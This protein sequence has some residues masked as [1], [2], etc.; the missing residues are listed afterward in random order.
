MLVELFTQLSR[1]KSLGAQHRSL[2]NCVT[3]A[4]LM[5]RTF[6]VQSI[7]VL[8]AALPNFVNEILFLECFIHVSLLS[9]VN[10]VKPLLK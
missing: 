2:G 1:Q 5:M 4:R 10:E 7:V 8:G 9:C 3:I 6:A